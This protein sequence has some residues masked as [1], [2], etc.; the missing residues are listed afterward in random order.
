MAAS[1]SES[2]AGVGVHRSAAVNLDPAFNTKDSLSCDQHCE[3]L[4]QMFYSM[5]LVKTLDSHV[6]GPSNR[7]KLNERTDQLEDEYQKRWTAIVLQHRDTGCYSSTT[8]EIHLASPNHFQHGGED[9]ESLCNLHCEVVHRG[10]GCQIR[11]SEDSSLANVSVDEVFSKDIDKDLQ[12]SQALQSEKASFQMPGS[13]GLGKAEVASRF[14][15]VEKNRLSNFSDE[16]PY[17]K[18]KRTRSTMS[19]NKQGGEQIVQIVKCHQRDA[20]IFRTHDPTVTHLLTV[21]GDVKD[22]RLSTGK[23]DGKQHLPFSDNGHSRLRPYTTHK[24][25]E[26]SVWK[27]RG[28]VSHHLISNSWNAST[29]KRNSRQSFVDKQ[30]ENRDLT[31]KLRVIRGSSSDLEVPVVLPDSHIHPQPFEKKPEMMVF[32]DWANK[33]LSVMELAALHVGARF[34]VNRLCS[35]N[36]ERLLKDLTKYLLNPKADCTTTMTE[37]E[38][39][40]QRTSSA[41]D[42]ADS[43]L[44][45]LDWNE[46]NDNEVITGQSCQPA[47]NSCPI[48][49]GE[50]S[51]LLGKDHSAV[52][53]PL[54][55]NRWEG[56]DL[57]KYDEQR[58]PIAHLEVVCTDQSSAQHAGNSKLPQIGKVTMIIQDRR[59]L[60]FLETLQ[61]RRQKK[62]GFGKLIIMALKTTRSDI[63]NCATPDKRREYHIKTID[64]IIKVLT[65]KHKLNCEGFEQGLLIAAKD[66][67]DGPSFLFFL[68]LLIAKVNDTKSVSQTSYG[69]DL[70]SSSA[71]ARCNNVGSDEAMKGSDEGGIICKSSSEC[72][73]ADAGKQVSRLV[74]LSKKELLG[75]KD[76]VRKA[77]EQLVGFCENPEKL[78]ASLRSV[79]PN[80][81]TRKVCEPSEHLLH[82]R[83]PI[84]AVMTE[85]SNCGFRLNLIKGHLRENTEKT[86]PTISKNKKQISKCKSDA[87][88][89]LGAEKVSIL[90][91]IVMG[92]RPAAGQCSRHTLSSDLK[93]FSE[94]RI[95]AIMQNV[96]VYASPGI[97]TITDSQQTLQTYVSA[98]DTARKV[99]ID[100]IESSVVTVDEVGGQRSALLPD[101][102]SGAGGQQESHFLPR[103][104]T[105]RNGALCTEHWLG[106][107]WRAEMNHDRG[108]RQTNWPLSSQDG[109]VSQQPLA[110]DLRMVSLQQQALPGNTA[111]YACTSVQQVENSFNPVQ[112]RNNCVLPVQQRQYCVLPVQQSVVPVQQASMRGWYRHPLAVSHLNQQ[113]QV[114][115]SSSSHLTPH[116][117]SRHGHPPCYQQPTIVQQHRQETGFAAP[118]Q[119]IE[120][121]RPLPETRA[122]TSDQSTKESSAHKTRTRPFSVVD[123]NL[124]EIMD[125]PLTRSSPFTVNLK[126]SI[127]SPGYHLLPQIEDS[128]LG[129]TME[130]CRCYQ[131]KPCGL[132]CIQRH[133]LS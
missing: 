82:F 23:D 39:S 22:E 15:S 86:V 120:N 19:D 127:W 114:H 103:E 93:M 61:Q 36:T 113:Q 83:L 46:T 84:E 29:L 10:N 105:K 28:S 41:L 126:M 57:N 37:K 85:M 63:D 96:G 109:R 49:V 56:H 51:R 40:I 122:P 110:T 80:E 71:S 68:K 128:C 52:I 117:L 30:G 35:K 27:C 115:W 20:N 116:L 88:I 58:P 55:F 60:W 90:E 62:K 45:S 81:Q 108:V 4:D 76:D 107:E 32:D 77:N 72:F 101:T 132:K 92:T 17:T 89:G 6:T 31:M 67:E 98:E 104:V 1:L 24:K 78:S 3:L 25:V 75:F 2:G 65:E 129:E 123:C 70:S 131:K 21:A 38:I 79:R 5:L 130:T 14:Q 106:A 133:W 97:E 42:I 74:N 87:D 18:T 13:E 48:S 8:D 54:I 53:L 7:V 95:Q 47:V 59:A 100:P 26:E 125:N 12:H 66:Q 73:S 102:S 11:Q 69:G 99:T 44:Q 91:S 119:R 16:T 64:S 111:Q 118:K 124:G 9:A 34:A 43:T 33:T 94:N 50:D 121:I 112:Q